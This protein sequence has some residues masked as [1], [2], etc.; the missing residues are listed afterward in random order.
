VSSN[1]YTIPITMIGPS[2]VG[3]T[4]LLAAMYKTWSEAT[5]TTDL[6]LT[7]SGTT[8]LRIS[9]AYEKLSQLG[10]R[11]KVKESV[12]GTGRNGIMQFDFEVGRK[13]KRPRFTLQFTDYAGEVLLDTGGELLQRVTDQLELSPVIMLAI[14]TP[15]LMY[16]DG[17]YHQTLNKPDLM[18]ELVKK[19]M[20]QDAR[21]RLLVLV[22]LKCERYVETSEGTEEVLAAIQKRYKALMAHLSHKDV[23]PRIG[24]VVIPVQT[25]GNVRFKDVTETEN[26]LIFN[27][28]SYGNREFKPVD[29]QQPLRFALR[30]AI[31]VYRRD[32]RGV[33][34]KLFDWLRRTDPALVKALDS[35]SAVPANSLGVRI[36]QTHPHLTNGDE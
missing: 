25:T 2:A 18:Y 16:M 15:A 17:R 9:Q 34:R 24:C 5:D 13:N 35:F 26:G 12:A 20:Q 30:F 4:S 28:R 8:P 27:Y 14:D 7:P 22:P 11:V 29:S 6:E 3:K 23:Q 36:L 31:N 1:R 19:I 21:H 33:F 32:R 10:L